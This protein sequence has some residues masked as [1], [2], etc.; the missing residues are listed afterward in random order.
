MFNFKQIMQRMKKFEF[1]AESGVI[2]GNKTVNSIKITEIE[3][4]LEI[5]D[6]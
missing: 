3:N 2:L 6:N 1:F 5:I 4:F